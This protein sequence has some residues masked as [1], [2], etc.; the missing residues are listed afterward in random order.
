M[1][2]RRCTKFVLAAIV[3]AMTTSLAQAQER[4][5]QVSSDDKDGLIVIPNHDSTFSVRH[6]NRDIRVEI[7]S[8]GGYRTYEAYLD[9]KSYVAYA[10]LDGPQKHFIFDPLQRRFRTLSDNIIVELAPTATLEDILAEHGLKWGRTYPGLD[11]SVI[12]VPEGMNPTNLVDKLRLDRRITDARVTFEDQFRRRATTLDHTDPYASP[13]HRTPMD[14]DNLTS[15]IFVNSRLDVAAAVPTFTVTMFNLGLTQTSNAT[16]R[17]ELLTIVQDTSTGTSN[18]TKPDLILSDDAQILPLDPKGEPFETIVSFPVESLEAGKTYFAL[19]KVLGGEMPDADSEVLTQRRSGFTLDHLKR[20]R[21]TCVES[22][23]ERMGNGTDPL[24]SHQ[25]HLANT[26]QA[27]FAMEGGAADEDLRMAKTLDDG[28]TGAG[29]KVAVV[30]TGLELCHPDLKA[31]VEQ[32]ASFNFNATVAEESTENRWAFRLEST[33]PFNF[34]P[35]HGHGSAVAGLIAATANNNIGGRGVAPGAALRGYNMLNSQQGVHILLASLGA[36]DFQPDS[37][38]VEIFNMSFGKLLVRPSK[39]DVWEEQI[40]LNGVRKLR[41]GKGA[42]YV[43][44]AGNGFWRC[45]SL[46]RELNRDIGC[47][48]SVGDPLHSLPYLIQVG[49]YN[50]DG[51]KSSY[52]SVGANI[53]V[54]APG[55]EYGYSKPAT[56]TVD[57]MGLDRGFA[58]LGQAIGT[59]YL[60][61]RDATLNPNGDYTS[62]MNGTSAAAPNVTG[63]VAILLEANPDFT[64]RDIKHILAN[65]ARKIHPDI[66]PASM[67][68]ESLTRTLRLPW[69]ENAAGYEFHEAYGFGA[70]AIDDAVAF[71]EDHEP[72]SLGD[73]L[74][75]AWFELTQAADIPDND[76]SGL[77]QTL[78]VQGL[79]SDANIEAIVV[80]IDWQHEFPNDLGVHLIS[81]AGTRSVISQVFNE[82]LAVKNIGTFTWRMLTNAFYGEDPIGDWRLE[83]FDADSGDVGQLF[84]WRLRVYYGEHL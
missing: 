54:S 73:F 5:F 72:D 27:A 80:E 42:I 36:S 18:G 69:T 37:T 31:N 56:I 67:T 58:V 76:L 52:S 23:R 47:M 34:E 3:V 77:D 83:I 63:A 50:A 41:S 30:D 35:D 38:D 32:G 10:A 71:A 60:L 16:L 79:A 39:L 6:E 40:L 65:S 9:N 7:S 20:V 61:E 49:A 53:W 4:T 33:D 57:P 64:W 43:K 62:L 28:P 19:F 24:Q 8:N 29:V 84:S 75:S 12:R 17:S 68:I 70:V 74:E 82:T 59:N 66:G 2:L 26:G 44:S 78:R 48:A 55:G 46:F 11:F 25:W 51:Y 45:N 14:K 1:S 81:P 15:R 13:Y 22:V 21:H